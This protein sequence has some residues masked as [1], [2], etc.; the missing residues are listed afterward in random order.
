M[1]ALAFY[2][3]SASFIDVKSKALQEFN[4]NQS[5]HYLER[6]KTKRKKR[7]LRSLKTRPTYTLGEIGWVKCLWHYFS[8]LLTDTVTQPTTRCLPLSGGARMQV[9]CINRENNQHPRTYY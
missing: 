1:P 6:T 8:S 2:F 4:F 7:D 9:K 3:S 5:I